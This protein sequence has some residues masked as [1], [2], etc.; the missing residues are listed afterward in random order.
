M[1]FLG[2]TMAAWT[3]GLSFYLLF[4]LVTA[5]QLQTN[6]ETNQI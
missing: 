2:H 4:L 5:K 3:Y 1:Y 6:Q